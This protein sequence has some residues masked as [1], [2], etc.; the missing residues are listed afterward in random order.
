MKEKTKTKKITVCGM[1]AALYVVTGFISYAMGLSSGAIQVRISEAMVVLG[2]FTNL[3]IP[4]V[5]LGCFLFNLLSGCAI[6]D[7]IFGTIASLIGVTG[8]WLIGKIM[9]KNKGMKWL[10]TLPNILSNTLIVPLI[11]IYAYGMTDSTYG[12]LALSVG[13]GE[14]I[15]SGV[16]GMLLFYLIKPFEGKIKEMY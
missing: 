12:A 3:A 8:T 10:I 15:S 2:A 6:P 11:L 1:I 9:N 4:G 16:L 13:A 14:V 7:I 5:T